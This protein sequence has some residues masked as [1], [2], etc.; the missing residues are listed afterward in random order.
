MKARILKIEKWSRKIS[1]LAICGIAVCA[2]LYFY[3]LSDS[4]FNA[5]SRREKADEANFLEA[6]VAILESDYLA[7]L[8]LINLEYAKS[9]GFIDSADNTTYVALDHSAVSMIS[10]DNEI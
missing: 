4:V 9:L 10:V 6:S 3:F 8:S 7:K 5:G 1:F 2:G